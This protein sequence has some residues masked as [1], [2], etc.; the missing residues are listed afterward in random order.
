M[1]VV[2]DSCVPQFVAR[3]LEVLQ[4]DVIWIGDW[5]KDPGDLVIL[6]FAHAQGRTVITLDK[7]Y[8]ELAVLE[9]IPHS[10]IVRLVDLSLQQQVEVCHQVLQRYEN[11]LIG[12]AIVTVNNKRVR[13]RPPE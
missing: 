2:A 4:H 6:N 1:K 8:G 11:D 9:K 7:D 3:Q 10:G 12:G 13:I 5:E